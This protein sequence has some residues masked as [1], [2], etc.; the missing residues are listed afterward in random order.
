[1]EVFYED[2]EPMCIIC[3]ATHTSISILAISKRKRPQFVLY[4]NMENQQNHIYPYN[5]FM[6]VWSMRF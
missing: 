1:M 5:I 4:V 2:H 3:F 6:C